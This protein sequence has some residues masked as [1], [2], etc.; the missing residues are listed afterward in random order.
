M[1]A[2]A[3]VRVDVPT[4]ETAGSGVYCYSPLMPLASI[5]CELQCDKTY[6]ELGENFFDR[7]NHKALEQRLV[8]R[9]QGLGYRVQLQ[10]QTEADCATS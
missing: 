10:P 8:Q 3:S 5:Y 9:L 6:H 1:R 4:R 7:L 2:R